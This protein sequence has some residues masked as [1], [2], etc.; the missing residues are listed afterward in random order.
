MNKVIIKCCIVIFAYL[1]VLYPL[2]INIGNISWSFSLTSVFNL[3]PLFGLAAFTLLWLHAI[4]GAFE[5]WIRK[6]IDFDQFVQNT[7]VAILFCIILHPLLLLIPLGFNFTRVF[8]YGYFYIWLGIIGWLL[9]ITYDIGKVFR[10][11]SFFM[12]NWHHILLISNIGFLITFF[13]S[14][15]VGSDLQSGLL[16]TVWIF[17]GITAII[18]I[19]WTY[20]IDRSWQKQ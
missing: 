15:G 16:K 5:P 8:G 18:A 2:W 12:K 1:A 10:K 3:F 4:S 17:Y 7:S 14:L 19:I 9:L 6:Y 13:H 20:G 11:H